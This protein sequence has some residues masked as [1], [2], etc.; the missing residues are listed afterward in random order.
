MNVF[1][2]FLIAGEFSHDFYMTA[3]KVVSVWVS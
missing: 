1:P 3:Y 2:H